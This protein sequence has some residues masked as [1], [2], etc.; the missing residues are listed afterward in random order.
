MS[1]LT[2]TN[3]KAT[4]ETAS[5]AVSGVAAAWCKFDDAATIA[6]SFNIASSVDVQTGQWRFSKTNEMSSTNYIVVGA[7]GNAINNFTAGHNSNSIES[8]ANHTHSKYL[9]NGGASDWEDFGSGGYGMDT[10]HGDLA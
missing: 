8:S 10:V 5:R 7:N 6:D 2:V 1:T 3:I 4:G 9:V